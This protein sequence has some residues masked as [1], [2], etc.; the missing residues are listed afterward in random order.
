VIASDHAPHTKSE[1][2]QGF[3]EA[4]S[5]IPGVETML[6]LLMAAFRERRITLMSIIKKTSWTPSDLL[7]VPRAGFRPGMRADFALYGGEPTPITAEDLHSRAGWTPY[8]GMPGLFPGRVIRDGALVYD[9]GEFFSRPPRWYAGRGY[10]VR[11]LI[12]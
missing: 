11:E 12:E 4:P 9:G 1:K 7:G 10:Q 2:E 5:G 8:E 3:S 6:P